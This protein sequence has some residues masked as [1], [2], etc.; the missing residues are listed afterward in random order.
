MHDKGDK[1]KKQPLTVTA[2]TKYIKHQFDHDANLTHVLLKG[3]IS[4]FVHHSRGHYYFTLKDEQAQIRAIMFRQHAEQVKVKLEDGMNVIVEG[5]VSVYIASGTYQIQVTALQV[6]GVGDLYLQ[7]EQLK[8]KLAKQGLFDARHKKP[9]PKFPKRIGIITSPTGAAIRDIISTIER[10]YKLAELIVFPTIVQGVDAKQSIVDSIK[11]AN[12][13]GGIDV[14]ILGRGGGS[15]EDLWAFNEEIV[16]NAIFQSDVP[17]IS[18]VGHETD[19]T[20]SDF[21]SDL[22]AATPTAAA[23]LAVPNKHDLLRYL[24]QLHHRMAQLVHTRIKGGKDYLQHLRNSFV[25]KQP[26]RI[27]EQNHYKLD[28]LHKQLL[29][30]SPMA[31]LE[32]AKQQLT[33]LYQ[34]LLD[35]Y[36]GIIER[37]QQTFQNMAEKLELVNPLHLLNKG[38]SITRKNEEPLVS[39]QHVALN[40]NITIDLKDGRLT[41]KVLKKGEKKYE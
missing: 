9:I 28:R 36:K 12:R 41:A 35:L 40:D 33:P 26:G 13:V 11:R 21:I 3:E 24:N 1:M 10:R 17:I 19:V 7:F 29:I 4:N 32:L 38:Y 30:Y 39:I 27:F 23:E 34:R 5:Y 14:I 31:K 2:L 6:D 25:F 20:I 18:A 37:K 8:E 16:V 15:I 22:R